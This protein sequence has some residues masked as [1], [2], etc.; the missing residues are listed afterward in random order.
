MMA[1]PFILAVF[2]GIAALFGLRQVSI[3]IWMAAFVTLLYALRQHVT[4]ALNV[5]L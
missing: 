2:A 1:L 4:A 5:V 3:W